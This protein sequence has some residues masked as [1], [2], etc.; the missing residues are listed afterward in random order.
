MTV[1]PLQMELENNRLDTDNSVRQDNLEK[2]WGREADK[3]L[4]A[5]YFY[6]TKT[7]AYIRI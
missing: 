1:I 4:L 6:K 3:L 5:L 7:K 2:D